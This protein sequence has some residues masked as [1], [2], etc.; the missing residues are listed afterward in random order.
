MPSPRLLDHLIGSGQQR[1]RD[2]EAEGFGGLEVDHRLE[3]CR[4]LHR[5]VGGFFTSEDSIDVAGG[6]AELVE[7]IRSVG[8]Q[9]PLVMKKRYG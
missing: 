4:R 2:G 9:D 8:Y 3:L 1:F 5:Q 6:T 7:R